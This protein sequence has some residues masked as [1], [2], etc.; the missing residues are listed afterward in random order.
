MLR[1]A[2]H[3]KRVLGKGVKGHKGT[4]KG[5]QRGRTGEYREGQAICS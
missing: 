1:L 4:I 2:Q 3:L 5:L